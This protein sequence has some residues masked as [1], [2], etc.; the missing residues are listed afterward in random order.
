MLD[1]F[2]LRFEVTAATISATNVLSRFACVAEGGETARTAWLPDDLLRRPATVIEI[3]TRSGQLAAMEG[4]LDAKGVSLAV[5]VQNFGLMAGAADA[6][7]TEVD[8]DQFWR[9]FRAQIDRVDQAY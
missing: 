8:R 7:P 4:Y 6:A 9:L 5:S 2:A 1:A 3:R